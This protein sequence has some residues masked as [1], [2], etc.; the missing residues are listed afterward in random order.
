MLAGMGNPFSRLVKPQSAEHRT[1]LANL[2]GQLSPQ[3][4]SYVS[5]LLS[6]L[7]QQGIYWSQLVTAGQVRPL[8]L[9]K[10]VTGAIRQH[11]LDPNTRAAVNKAFGLVLQ[12]PSGI[13]RRRP[14][15]PEHQAVTASL[16]AQ[17]SQQYRSCVS[18]FLYY[19]E[20]Q[21]MNWSQLAPTDR[22]RF[23]QLEQ[24]VNTAIG[25]KALDAGTRA[26]LNRAFSLELKS[27]TR[28]S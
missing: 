1:L 19:L 2:P 16:P 26:A 6:H 20:Q 14:V 8:Q 7:E 15:I 21:G 11:E 10:I 12:G 5:C 9:E 27:S 25:Q 13:V 18:R 23:A 22:E 3:H 17:L 28:R 4:R 24:L